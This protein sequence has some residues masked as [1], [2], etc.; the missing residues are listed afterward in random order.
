MNR[1]EKTNA[2]R[3][4]DKAGVA[5]EAIQYPSTG[6]ALD[7]V[8]VAA[9]INEAPERVFKTLVLQGHDSAYYVCVIP[10]QAELDLKKAAA[11][12][13]VKSLR[14]LHVDEIRPVTGY[15]RGGC[16]PIGMKKPYKTAFDDSALNQPYMLVSA[17]VIGAQIKVKSQDII[18]VCGAS[19]AHLLRD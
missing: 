3:M 16:S 18:K 2:M 15:V 13:K 19:T 17:G 7:A 5:Y 9:L 11:A 12:F 6:E 4:L 8:T 14:M 1:M 10:G